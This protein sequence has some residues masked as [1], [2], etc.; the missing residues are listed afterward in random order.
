MPPIQPTI[1]ASVAAAPSSTLDEHQEQLLKREDHLSL[2]E[3]DLV[4]KAKS[5]SEWDTVVEAVE[6]EVAAVHAE[7]APVVADVQK[8]R[9][10]M[11]T[12]DAIAS[13]NIEL[14]N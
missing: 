2:L 1:V 9:E 8:W 3:G 6:K 11:K 4:V 12:Q 10:K 7:R 14:D 13:A 5:L